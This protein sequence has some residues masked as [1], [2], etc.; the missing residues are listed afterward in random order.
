[1][2]RRVPLKSGGHLVIDQSEALTAIDVNTG[3][4]VG[5]DDLEETVTKNNLEASREIAR[6]L[7]LRNIGGIIVLDFVDMDKQSNREKVWDALNKALA[8]D[9]AR[10]NVT[11]I[12]ELGLVEMTRKRTRESLNQLLTHTCP[13]CEGAA[14]IKSTTTVANEVLREV[15][16]LGGQVQADKIEVECAPEVAEYLADLEREYL[17]AL[18]KKFQKQVVVT[19]NP[20]LKPDQHKVAGRMSEPVQGTGKVERKRS[21]RGGRGSS[22]K[23]GGGK[24]APSGKEAAA[25]ER[26]G[27]EPAAKSSRRGRGRRGGRRGGTGA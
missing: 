23:R 16:R 10:C 25:K 21:A 19:G 12:S 3:S 14:V 11:K 27:Q 15:R 26:E 13:V 1:M 22:G 2:S 5:K 6:Q 17:D 20:A 8:A 7:R 4:F 24:K 9:H 18:E